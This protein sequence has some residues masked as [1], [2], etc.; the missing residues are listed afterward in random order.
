MDEILEVQLIS[1]KESYVVRHPVLRK[2]R[3]LSSCVFEGDEL[4]STVHIGGFVNNKL[5]AVATFLEND[6]PKHNFSNAVQL[7]GMAVL[8]QYQG[9]NYGKIL[10]K[11]G[12]TLLKK[13]RRAVVWMNAREIAV[14]FYKIMGYKTVGN[15]FEI[16]KAGKHYIMYKK[17]N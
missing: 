8:E 17:L 13:K 11:F 6:N 3:P 4:E 2:G 7:R 1:A 9:K 10:L 12:E 15:I 16:P 14:E 5:V